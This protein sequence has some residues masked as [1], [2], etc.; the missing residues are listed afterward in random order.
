MDFSLF[1]FAIW[2]R[3]V[4]NKDSDI[5]PKGRGCSEHLLD[6]VEEESIYTFF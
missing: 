2:I 6:T 1:P 5:L 3:V 4:V